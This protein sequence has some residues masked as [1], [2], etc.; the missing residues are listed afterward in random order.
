MIKAISDKLKSGPEQQLVVG[1]VVEQLV[2]NGWSLEQ[3]VFG[4]NE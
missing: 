4:R 3:I 2:S 1:P